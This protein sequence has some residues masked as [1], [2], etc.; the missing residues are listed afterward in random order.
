M[1]LENKNEK[2]VPALQVSQFPLNNT[3]MVNSDQQFTSLNEI[4]KNMTAI[5]QNE[6]QKPWVNI[7]VI[8][9]AF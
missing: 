1:F 8:A 5:S 3:P 4:G 7:S 9:M 6:V 2:L